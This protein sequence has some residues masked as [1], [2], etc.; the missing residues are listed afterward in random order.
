MKAVPVTATGVG[1]KVVELGVPDSGLGQVLI[2]VPACGACNSDAIV[3]EC[4]R[5]G[6]PYP[7][8]PG[9]EVGGVVDAL[10][11]GMTPHAP[12]YPRCTPRKRVC[13]DRD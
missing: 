8:V 2:R 10:G 3:V 11:T 1:S 7:R 6:I 12:D 4:R 5:P 13:A 9:H